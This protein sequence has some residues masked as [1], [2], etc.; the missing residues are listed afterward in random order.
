MAIKNNQLELPFTSSDKAKLDSVE[1]G[2]EANPPFA[3]Q[4]VA[5]AGLDNAQI[6][7]A[8]RVKQAI[9]VFAP[10]AG[11]AS[12]S[13]K[14][15]FLNNSGSSI[16]ALTPVRQNASGDL[17][18]IDVSEESEVIGMLG[19]TE[20]V[21]ANGNSGSVVLSGL[22]KEVTTSFNVGDVLY[23]SPSGELTSEVPDIGIAGFSAGDF[24]VQVGKVLKNEDDDLEKDILVQINV[25]GQL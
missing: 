19:I 11:D 4:A 8:L 6:M 10:T 21:I 5:E 20:T 2:A 16:S 9:D 22:L 13:V 24:I 25:R 3:S 12:S 15:T 7:T 23:L 17:R 14:R 18:E 1:T